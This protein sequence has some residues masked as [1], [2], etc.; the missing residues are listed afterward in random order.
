MLT[1][2]FGDDVLD[3]GAGTD[4]MSGGEGDDTY[5][6]DAA[7]AITE[8]ADGGYDTV[9]TNHGMTLQD[10]FEALVGTGIVGLSLTGNAVANVIVGA[11]GADVLDGGAEDDL[12]TGGSGDDV[13]KGGVGDDRLDGGAGTQDKARFSGVRS[14]YTVTQ[15]ENGA[16]LVKDNRAD[17][18]GQ[19]TVSNIELFEFSNGTF[20][21]AELSGPTTPGNPTPPT[22]PAT[23][24]TPTTPTTPPAGMILIGTS[25]ANRL[26]GGDGNDQL[27]GKLGKDVLTGGAGQDIFTFDTRASKKT[28]LDTIRDY[29]V[30]EDTIWLDNKVFKKLGKGSASE[31]GKLKKA[32]FKIGDK[33]KD[34]NDYLV[35]NKK[36]GI[37]FYDA[38]GS[39]AAKAIE[40]AKLSKNLK[41]TCDDFFVV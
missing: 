28:N 7:D 26:T 29:S 17:G 22:P 25:Q 34:G 21:L 2:G 27:Y 1:G 3:G 19:D 18:D 20:T 39:G 30:A 8:A 13:L 11:D 6:V 5:V 14:D 9:E 32:F 23:P 35:Y 40:I 41:L 24:T 4:E 38:D 10:N 33:A 15:G 16:Y 37:L 36:S 31:P 12:L